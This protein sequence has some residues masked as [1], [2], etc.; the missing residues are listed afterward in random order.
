MKVLEAVQP[1]ASLFPGQQ[2]DS[3]PDA[4][5]DR[6]CYP[7][8]LDSPDTVVSSSCPSLAPV[9]YLKYCLSNAVGTLQETEKCEG[10]T[11]RT[12]QSRAQ[13][14]ASAGARL[15]RLG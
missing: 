7:A 14:S 9:R 13:V 10:E 3:R 8:S 12:G 15:Q 6:C 5:Q 11:P 1:D 2:H 4:D